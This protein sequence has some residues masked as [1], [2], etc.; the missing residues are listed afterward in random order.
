MMDNFTP[1]K[2]ENPG[3]YVPDFTCR[4]KRE[5][6]PMEIVPIKGIAELAGV[7]TPYLDE[8]ITN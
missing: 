5:D 3:N 6:V 8:V 1:T 4:Y 2:E 7:C